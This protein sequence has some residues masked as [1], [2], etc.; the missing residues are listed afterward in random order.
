[1]KTIVTEFISLDG[2]VQAPGGADEDKDGG[3]SHGGWSMKY[4]DPEIMGSMYTETR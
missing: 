4:F 1:M 2:V 3:F